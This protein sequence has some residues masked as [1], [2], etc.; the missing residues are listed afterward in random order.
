M[1]ARTSSMR[2]SSDGAAATRSDIPV[3]RF[4]KTI[5]PENGARR[6]RSSP[7]NGMFAASSTCETNP[8]T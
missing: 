5:T 7:L 3:L 1:T 6:R 2:V 4:S 8:G